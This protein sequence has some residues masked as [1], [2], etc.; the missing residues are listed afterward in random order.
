M[1]RAT[2]YSQGESSHHE[3][4]LKEV[5]NTGILNSA[6]TSDRPFA[7]LN[8]ASVEESNSY[9]ND[10]GILHPSCQSS[11]STI[12]DTLVHLNSTN[13]LSEE[14]EEISHESL[15]E[16]IRS[17]IVDSGILHSPS[18]NSNSS[19]TGSLMHLDSPNFLSTEAVTSRGIIRS[20][21]DE[22]VSSIGTA[23]RQRHD[24]GTQS[25]GSATNDD[26]SSQ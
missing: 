24:S 18:Q 11:N 13:N 26:C 9:V 10:L 21:S 5:N 8:S 23:K 14:E 25:L 2:G 17:D 15:N 6:S 19:I 7:H 3:S 4:D 12:N 20:I 1:Q 22:D 16:K